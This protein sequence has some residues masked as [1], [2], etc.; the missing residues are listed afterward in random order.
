[1]QIRHEQMQV[2]SA[3]K[4][5]GV[6]SWPQDVVMSDL[7]IVPN[8]SIQLTCQ[9]S[10]HPS[11]QGDRIHQDSSR[12]LP[13]ADRP[14]REAAGSTIARKRFAIALVLF[15]LG[16]TVS[17]VGHRKLNTTVPNRHILAPRN[18]IGPKKMYELVKQGCVYI[19][20]VGPTVRNSLM[21][22]SQ[23]ELTS[24]GTSIIAVIQTL[25]LSSG[26]RRK[27][28]LE[29][30]S[31]PKKDIYPNEEITINYG[32]HELFR[33]VTVVPLTLAAVIVYHCHV[34]ARNVEAPGEGWCSGY[35]H[36]SFSS[37]RC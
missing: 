11:K 25:W 12:E 21:P 14:S 6:Y 13:Q 33:W 35:R 27:E 2:K 8:T 20:C 24:R 16:E 4:V 15:V 26:R 34:F 3:M 36:P 31:S 5:D 22:A 17:Y 19:L 29:L 37:A 18:R 10:F 28:N 9:E 32:R 30:S 1:M 23:L 7:Y